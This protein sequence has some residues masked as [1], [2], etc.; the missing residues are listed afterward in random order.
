MLGGLLQANPGPGF[1][2]ALNFPGRTKKEKRDW[3]PA[4]GR[5]FPHL[6]ALTPT[7]HGP[8]RDQGESRDL[9]K[10]PCPATLQWGER[11]PIL[12]HPS[13]TGLPAWPAFP[14]IT[15]CMLRTDCGMRVRWSRAAVGSCSR[16]AAGPYPTVAHDTD[17]WMDPGKQIKSPTPAP[18][19][20]YRRWP[21]RSPAQTTEP[22]R[23]LVPLLAAARRCYAE[24]ER[25]VASLRD[26]SASGD[27]MR[28]PEWLAGPHL[29]GTKHRWAVP[30]GRSPPDVG[31]YGRLIGQ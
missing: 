6:A 1:S 11:E 22:V 17:D 24:R 21:A 15:E 19:P 23:P 13:R 3:A 4:C 20:R 10:A 18:L 25:D 5:A 26:G 14:G 28:R 29:L 12:P 31:V 7:R 9:T 27:T 16:G 2:H 30:I 8:G